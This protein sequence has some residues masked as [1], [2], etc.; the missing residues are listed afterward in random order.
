MSMPS[1]P[2]I[3]AR[4]FGRSNNAVVAKLYSH[5]LNTPLV[6]HPA[7]GERLM[8]AYLEGAVDTHQTVSATADRI[9]VI[10]VSGGLV[11]RDMDDGSGC[12]GP[13]SYA[14]IR[15]AFD[16]ALSDES[17]KAIVFRM[18]SPGGMA[19]GV[20]DL[21]DHIYASRGKKP[22]V[23]QVDDM[24]YSGAY[25]IAAACDRVQVTRTGGVGSIG[26]VC[27]HFEQSAYD[28]KVGVKV[29]PIYSGA[30]KVDGNP[31]EPLT[32]GARADAQLRVDALRAL[33]AQ[34]VATY[35]GKSVEEMLATEA[36]DYS[37]ADGVSAGLADSV[38][39][40]EDLLS[41]LSAEA[42]PAVPD[43]PTA[44][45]DGGASAASAAEQ[46][47]SLVLEST[48]DVQ[49]TEAAAALAALAV[50][51]AS[52]LPDGYAKAVE[53]TAVIDA[54][55]A[56]A[57]R[58][59]LAIVLMEEASK[60]TPETAQARIDHARSVADLCAAANLRGCEV[61]YV[62]ANTPIAAVRAALVEAVADSGPELVT[63]IPQERT[64]AAPTQTRADAT[65]S[66]RRAAA[67]GTG[68]N[69]RQ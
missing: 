68:N 60:V 63:A 9:A 10:N 62:R 38:G 25:A 23:A 12:P 64:S 15:K 57:L 44:E 21:T 43:Q 39:T 1:K 5:G 42:E 36:Q 28:A 19:S 69:P 50:A 58:D 24:A 45:G 37:G 59:D 27:Y 47:V 7:I 34:S 20:F 66:R 40:L 2:G 46:V 8:G 4:L 13:L 22:I 18:D 14:A 51:P 65:Y 53:R 11:N 52:Q 32:D 55:M 54:V 41:D 6:I 3:I 30:H 16:A 33:F 29:T 31:H 49:L 48:G 35:R 26:A 56:A 17:V 61:E 67:A